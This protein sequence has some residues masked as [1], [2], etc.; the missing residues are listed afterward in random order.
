MAYSL[1]QRIGNNLKV[2]VQGNN[3][4]DKGK[5]TRE[6]AGDGLES[7]NSIALELR[8]EGLDF[9]LD[10]AKI[11]RSAIEFS[12]QRGNLGQDGTDRDTSVVQD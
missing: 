1:F 11:G 10:T 3:T 2:E 4:L 7:G 8:E 5:G 12:E 9:G 6:L